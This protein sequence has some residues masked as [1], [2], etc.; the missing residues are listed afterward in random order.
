MI[1]TKPQIQEG[2]RTPSKINTK[3]FVVACVIFKM[4]KIKDKEKILK[5]VR[6]EKNTLS[7]EEQGQELCQISPQKPREQEVVAQH[8]SRSERKKNKWNSSSVETSLRNERETK[9]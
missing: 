6:E 8:I 4:Q 2:Q 1:D 9:R 7:V 5:E 3:M